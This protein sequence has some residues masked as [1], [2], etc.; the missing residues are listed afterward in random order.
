MEETFLQYVKTGDLPEV[1]N[2]LKNG[3]DVNFHDDSYNTALHYAAIHGQKEI[4][5]NL[6]RNGSDPDLQNIFELTASEMAVNIGRHDLAKEMLMLEDD[7]D[8]KKL[9]KRGCPELL[10]F[11]I[12]RMEQNNSFDAKEFMRF[13]CELNAKGV[14]LSERMTIYLEYWMVEYSYK[15]KIVIKTQNDGQECDLRIKRLLKLIEYLDENYSNDEFDD[16]DYTFMFYLQE[17]TNEINFVKNNLK[18]LPL[19]QL[20]FVLCIFLQFLRTKVNVEFDIYS[21]LINKGNLIDF[22][23]CGVRLVREY[24]HS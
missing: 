15:H 9:M 23:P 24:H 12:S 21:F 20:H 17:I 11:Q 6:L 8:L 19:M 2:C 16:L 13:Y 4:M 18:T 7:I 3:V 22:L 14:V 10:M 1:L 5:Y